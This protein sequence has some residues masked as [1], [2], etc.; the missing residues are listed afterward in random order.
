MVCTVLR[1]H[2]VGSSSDRRRRRRI[3]VVAMTD[4]AAAKVKKMA[5]CARPLYP[6]RPVVVFSKRPVPGMFFTCTPSPPSPI[7]LLLFPSVAPP[8]NADRLVGHRNNN[9][10]GPCPG[11]SS[12]GKKRT[13]TIKKKPCRVLHG[14]RG[15]WGWATVRGLN[16]KVRVP[17][18][19]RVKFGRLP[20]G[21]RPRDTPVIDA[22]AARRR[23]YRARP[24]DKSAPSNS[25][26]HTFIPRHLRRASNS[27]FNF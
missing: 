9:N 27:R 12:A 24:T 13:H 20:V 15:G 26:A 6:T 14:R 16:H 10:N 21:Y 25:T 18:G 22:S 23:T 8:A 19:R 4:S 11:R 17:N 5:V 1:L 7:K 3:V 2:R